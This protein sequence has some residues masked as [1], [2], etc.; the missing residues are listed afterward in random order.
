MLYARSA[1]VHTLFKEFG[2]NKA[3]YSGFA[4]DCHEKSSDG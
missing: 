4:A 3:Y 2:A 1:D